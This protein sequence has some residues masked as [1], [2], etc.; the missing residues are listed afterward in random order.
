MVKF[1]KALPD[2]MYVRSSFPSKS[3]DRA[4]YRSSIWAEDRLV[5]SCMADPRCRS[6]FPQEERARPDVKEDVKGVIPAW[7]MVT[8][9][10][11]SE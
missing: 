9:T 6:D 2:V 8:P 10:Y 5:V 4:F 11:V 7:K 3:I 1:Y